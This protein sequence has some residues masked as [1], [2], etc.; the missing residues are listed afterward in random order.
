LGSP[1]SLAFGGWSDTNNDTDLDDHDHNDTHI[2]SLGHVFLTSNDM[3][4]YTKEWALSIGYALVIARST[5]KDDEL[6]R[7][8]LRCDRG[9]KPKA[10]QES[11]RLID[12]KYQLA[13]H[14]RSNGWI[15]SCD[16]SKG[17]YTIY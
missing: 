15:L 12:C 16:Q 2:P 7:I 4:T 8:Y 1:D 9:G 10:G 13:G 17:N 3:V 5:T 14:K 11:S 6:T